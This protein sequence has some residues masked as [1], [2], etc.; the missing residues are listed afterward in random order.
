MR[1]AHPT[2]HFASSI[3]DPAHAGA[4]EWE[5]LPSLADSLADRLVILGT[6][7]RESTGGAPSR[8]FAFGP[9]ANSGAAWHATRPAAFDTTAQPQPF[10]EA[11]EGLAIREVTEPDLFRHFFGAP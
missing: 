11:L 2:S 8:R 7:A 6:R 4:I 1:N 10:R 9:A 3:R 5:E